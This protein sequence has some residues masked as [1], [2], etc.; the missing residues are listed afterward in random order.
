MNFALIFRRRLFVAIGRGPPPV[1]GDR[2]AQPT[3][4]PPTILPLGQ[5]QIAGEHS[6]GGDEPDAVQGDDAHKACSRK[7]RTA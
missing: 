4:T 5:P 2:Q 7:E 3:P 6:P 1:P